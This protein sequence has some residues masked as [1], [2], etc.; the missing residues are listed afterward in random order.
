MSTF[1]F[2][3]LHIA[4]ALQARAILGS[5]ST[6]VFETWPATGGEH[7]ARKDSGISQIFIL[8]I[9]N[10]ENLSNVNVVV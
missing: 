4:L 5:L 2:F 7:F 1:Q 8:I 6:R 10:G 9:S 3:R